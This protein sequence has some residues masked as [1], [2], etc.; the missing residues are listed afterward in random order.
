MAYKMPVERKVR[1]AEWDSSD[2]KA[3]V[4]ANKRLSALAKGVGRSSKRF[5]LIREN[6][7]K[8]ALAGARQLCEQI[9][10]PIDVRAVAD[11][12]DSDDHR[13]I[14]L[15][16]ELIDRLLYPRPVLTTLT[17]SLLVSAYCNR[18]DQLGGSDK[19][20]ALG[21]LIK[22]QLALRDGRRTG[23]ALHRL[24]ERSDMIFQ[25]DAPRRLFE[26]A[27]R[28]G[29]LEQAVDACGLA[30]YTQGRLVILVR[31]RYYIDSLKTI[32]VGE[33]SPLLAQV[34][35]SKVYDAR[36]DG[37]S[38]MGHAVLSILIRRADA[39]HISDAWRG[40]ILKIAG[41]P[42]VSP[43]HPLYQKWWAR[44]DPN[45][46][47]KAK[48]WLTGFDLKLFLK[49]LEQYG[50]AEGDMDLQRMYPA[51]KRF[52][53]GLIEQHLVKQS[54]LFISRSMEHY[55][56]EA[57]KPDELPVYA[58]VKNDQ[59]SMI[60]LNVDGIH[61]LEGSHNRA[62][63]GVPKLPSESKILDPDTTEFNERSLGMGLLE[64]F[65]RE[66]KRVHRKPDGLDRSVLMKS[67]HPDSF[68]W[69]RTAI[70]YLKN[71]G[72][73]INPEY[74]FSQEDYKVFKRWHGILKYVPYR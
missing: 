4:A 70:Q 48:G 14:E 44:I 3:F 17:L 68:S 23:G 56:K 15:T 39:H 57:Y 52:L 19:L 53:E 49:A 12:L 66:F 2:F 74:L 55:L 21:G 38:L 65:L 73:Q 13:G 24:A 60:Y 9:E 10:N 45:F 51:R 41:D 37:D 46:V 50:Q 33:N 27:K 16:Y 61:I 30:P 18:H 31:C 7:L 29:N 25:G 43:S 22:R 59:R 34:S 42:R 26:E 5:A 11:I 28:M 54:R 8:A 62:M 47:E 67:H 64:E 58:I 71:H 35:E 32:E 1:L 40:A 6:L 20:A 36:Y 72:V 69:Q 63:Y